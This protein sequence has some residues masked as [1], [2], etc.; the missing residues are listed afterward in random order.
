SVMRPPMPVPITTA[1]RAGSAPV[2]PASASASDAAANP[3]C[4]TRSTRRASFA[5]R[6]TVGS[7]S[8]TSHPI[9]TG[10]GEGSKRWIVAAA[11]LP[12]LSRDASASTVVPAGVLTPSPVTA[13]RGRPRASV[14]SSAGTSLRPHLGEHEV[15]RLADGR[16]TFE[17]VFGHFDVEALLEAHHQLD[18][19][20]AVGVEILLETGT[21]GDLP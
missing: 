20:E 12:L 18:E 15:D 16:D 2:S 6:Y 13:T 1:Q 11:D 10:S 5:P 3:S 17:V 7:K 19:V 21:L 4:V 9:R 8:M 14:A